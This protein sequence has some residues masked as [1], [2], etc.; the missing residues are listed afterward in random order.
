MYFTTSRLVS[1]DILLS[2]K[3]GSIK[4]KKAN[5]SQVCDLDKEIRV[6][7]KIEVNE[8]IAQHPLA[9]EVSNR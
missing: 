7:S 4:K 1:K 2:L 3:I 9:S 5:S 8:Q 6:S